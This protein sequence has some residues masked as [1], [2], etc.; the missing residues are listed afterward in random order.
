MQ[1]MP[2]HPYAHQLTQ[3]L[4]D[5]LWLEDLYGFCTH[6][7]FHSATDGETVLEVA[8]NPG[9]SLSWPGRRASGLR[10]LPGAIEEAND[11]AAKYAAP[12]VFAKGEATPRRMLEA[13]GEFDVV[14]FAGHAVADPMSPW[15]SRLVMNPDPGGRAS[16][17]AR[18][19]AG[20][21][22]R[23]RVVVLSACRTADG[24]MSRAEGL[25]SLARPF[26]AAGVQ[27]VVATLW[28]V[29]DHQASGLSERFHGELIQTHDAA[30]ALQRAQIAALGRNRHTAL[31]A[32]GAYVVVG[33]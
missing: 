27:S 11:V 20:V 29:Q 4:F 21:Q 8:L 28:D 1:I 9:R 32:W 6:C 26:V 14:H 25:M 24:A 16:L 30:V 7:T 12:A 19:I 18:D 22:A 33:A 17:T 13:L 10:P 23:A 31:G 5:A 3:D 2:S 15:L